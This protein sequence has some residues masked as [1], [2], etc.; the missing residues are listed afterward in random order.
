MAK[1]TKAAV[2]PAVEQEQTYAASASVEEV[3]HVCK[4]CFFHREH[5][6]ICRCTYVQ[7]F[8][9]NKKMLVVAQTAVMHALLMKRR[10][11]STAHSE[12]ML[13]A[14]QHIKTGAAE[15]LNVQLNNSACIKQTYHKSSKLAKLD[16]LWYNFHIVKVKKTR[17]H[18][19]YA[20]AK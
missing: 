7:H 12:Q 1:K 2:Q 13:K 16:C 14:I 18:P 6:G 15:C 5:N 3:A 20:Q 9:Q 8:A 17:A 4:N 11:L 10:L 19:K